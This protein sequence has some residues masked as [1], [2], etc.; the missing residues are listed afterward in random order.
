MKAM[1]ASS[2]TLFGEQAQSLLKDAHW[3]CEPK[4]DGIRTLV[5]IN[6]DGVQWRNRNDE[7]LLKPVPLAVDRTLATLP[8]GLIFDGEIVGERLYVF[9]LP[10]FGV[11]LVNMAYQRRRQTLEEVAAIIGIDTHLRLSERAFGSEGKEKMLR[12]ARDEHWEGIMFKHVYG[13]YLPGKRST[14]MLKMK[15]VKHIDCVVIET[16]VD[17]K[18]NAS[19]GVWELSGARPRMVEVGKCSLVGKEEVEPGD[20]I[21][22][23][24]LYA[25][26]NR[27]VQP[28]LIRKR[29]DKRPYSCTVD[30]LRNAHAITEPR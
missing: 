16:G 12:R 11:G 20:V 30:Q 18:E 24:Y 25:N 29:T 27:L 15:F 14:K 4:Y 26:N 21:E 17:N 8:S 13:L 19:L 6:E 5:V 1:L 9:D 10:Q 23:R 7:P 22:V 28:R 3:V 2:I